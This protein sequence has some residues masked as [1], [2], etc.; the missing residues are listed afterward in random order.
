MLIFSIL[1]IIILNENIVFTMWR[2]IMKKQNRGRDIA[3]ALNVQGRIRTLVSL[4]L[5]R[6]KSVSLHITFD[7]E[8]TINHAAI[9]DPKTIFCVARCTEVFKYFS[10][11][12]T[13]YEPLQL[14]L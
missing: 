3:T 7:L 6:H 5:P 11:H 12:L 2:K 4:R 1:D 14:R 9:C 13:N 10:A 8:M